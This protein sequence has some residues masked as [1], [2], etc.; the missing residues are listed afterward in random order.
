MCFYKKNI[1]C[2]PQVLIRTWHD[3]VVDLQPTHRFLQQVNRLTQCFVKQTAVGLTVLY[4]GA[5]K[6]SGAPYP[7]WIVP[8]AWEE[9]KL[10]KSWAKHNVLC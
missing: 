3:I 7:D 5:L 8:C 9:Y 4:R 6:A 10:C 1:Q 2:S